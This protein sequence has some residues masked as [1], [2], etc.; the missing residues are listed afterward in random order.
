[1]S[2]SK[3]FT[4]Q[5]IFAQ[6][7]SYVS[8]NRINQIA[9]DFQADRYYKDFKTYEHLVTLLYGIFNRCNSLREVVTGLQAWEQRVLHLG[10]D[11]H[12]RKSTVSDANTKRTSE[13]FEVI[14]RDLYNKYSRF[15]PDSRTEKKASRF[16]I[17][18]S[19][20]ISLFQEI[21]NNAGCRSIDGR[22]KGG[23]K[24]HTLMRSDQDVPCLIRMT[25]GAAA[26]SPFL[27]S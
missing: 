7:L 11:Y 8:H 17:I 16:F 15:L 24:V 14:Y 9:T 2:K 18:D 5:P 13:V 1:M 3:F 22:R 6:L 27:K 25:A 20:T 19:T 23:I 12:P 4:G 10:I 26:D 21:L